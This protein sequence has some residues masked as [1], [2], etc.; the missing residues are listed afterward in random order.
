MWLCKRK[1]IGKNDGVKKWTV[2]V[3]R[4]TGTYILASL[5][6]IE[7]KEKRNKDSPCFLVKVLSLRER[8]NFKEQI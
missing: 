2:Q 7:K 5:K 6:K 8:F 3:I 4:T 1:C